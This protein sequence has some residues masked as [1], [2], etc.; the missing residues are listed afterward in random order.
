MKGKVAIIE[1]NEVTAMVL[2]FHVDKLKDYETSQVY[3]GA[4]NFLNAEDDPGF[5][6][7]DIIMPDMNGIEAISL[8][9]KKN[10]KAHIIMVSSQNDSDT[11]FKALQA[12]A[13]GYLDKQSL[14]S[15]SVGKLLDVVKSGGSFMTPAVAKAIVDHFQGSHKKIEAL[16]DREQQVADAIRDGMSYKMIA[17]H[18]DLSIDTIR[19]HIKN[20]YSKLHI[21]SK[22]ELIKLMGGM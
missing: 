13:V 3:S 16:S 17:A 2:K 7:L 10:P 4:P 22:G 19:M 18:M 8:I 5:I 6:F 20:I 1:D 14:D 11:I 9:K 21:N 15:V 12:G